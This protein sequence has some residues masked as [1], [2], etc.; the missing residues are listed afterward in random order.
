MRSPSPYIGAMATKIILYR[1]YYL[2]LDP[3]G[4]GFKIAIEPDSPAGLPTPQLRHS[5]YRD[6]LVAEAKE[7]VDDLL[8]HPEP[9]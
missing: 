2:H 4:S 1:G 3:F 8:D 6:V 5:Q 9:C 7:I